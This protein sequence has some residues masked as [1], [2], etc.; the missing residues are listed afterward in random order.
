LI[1]YTA[2]SHNRAIR[3]NGGAVYIDVRLIGLTV[4]YFK[5]QIPWALRLPACAETCTVVRYHVARLVE[6][7]TW[8]LERHGMGSD[9]HP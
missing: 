1:E 2:T 8:H 4:C 7:G 3:N 9:H 6:L 5:F